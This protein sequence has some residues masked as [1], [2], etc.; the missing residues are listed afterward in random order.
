[1]LTDNNKTVLTP[2]D[3]EELNKKGAA[4]TA[5]EADTEKSA[6]AIQKK[7]SSFLIIV[8]L[9]AI[10]GASVILLLFLLYVL[11]AHAGIVEMPDFIKTL[12]G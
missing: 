8:C 2:D 9:Y 7:N 5:A 1:M 11:L 10:A 12:F 6:P 3:I 4:E